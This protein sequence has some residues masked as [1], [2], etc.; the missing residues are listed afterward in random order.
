MGIYE[1]MLN[2]IDGVADNNFNFQPASNQRGRN[3]EPSRYNADAA[4]P[5]LSN[6]PNLAGASRVTNPFDVSDKAQFNIIVTR[7]TRAITSTALPFALFGYQESINLYKTLI[8]ANLPSG[9]TFTSYT[10][11]GVTS[12]F[13]YTQGM[14][15]DTITVTC[16]EYPYPALLYSSSMDRFRVDYMRMTLSDANQTSQYSKSLYIYKRN[17]FGVEEKNTI[18]PGSYKSPTQYQSAIVDIPA[19]Y[20]VGKS[21]TL[22]STIIDAGAANFSVTYTV[23]VPKIVTLD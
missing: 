13:T 20:N 17:L 2:E 18:N 11:D 10:N 19:A 16:Q 12:T 6:I 22:I 15:V 1:D 21:V 8:T 7:P 4:L 9:V 23:F 5:Q 3:F 14:N